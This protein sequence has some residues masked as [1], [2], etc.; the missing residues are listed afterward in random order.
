MDNKAVASSEAKAFMNDHLVKVLLIDDQPIV[1][2]TVRRMLASE[3]ELEFK[4]LSDPTQAIKVA[5]EYEPT[6]ILQDLV[7]PQL[8]GMTLV[9]FFRANPATKLIPMIVLSSRE[10]ATTKAEAF[11]LG[12][13]DYIVKLPDKIELIARIRYHSQGYINLLQRNEAY[14]A[15]AGVAHDIKNIVTGIKGGTY[16][17]DQ[18]MESD[19]KMML[20]LGWN[21][22]KV[23]QDRI[24]QLVYNM[25]DYSKNASLKY[26]DVDIETQLA[27]VRDLIALRAK[28]SEIVVEL[29][30]HSDAKTLEGEG[31]SLHRCILNLAGNALD[32]LP[33]SEPGKLIIRSRLDDK[34]GFIALE[35]EDNGP[36]IP[37]DVLPTLFQAFSSSK[38]G[39]G[40]GLGLAV[41]KKIA[42][43]HG[44]DIVVKST[45]GV[46][47]VFSVR[48]PIRKPPEATA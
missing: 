25:L 3:K 26:E 36:G 7:M 24:N 18:A 9:K 39:K 46:G 35:V 42:L 43:K 31:L 27:N 16:M 48:I 10:E 4:F 34:E 23:S 11:A 37:E 28:G 29:D 8:D 40:T 38:G 12:A 30:I 2:E 13:N 45:I 47:A 33:E 21:I 1:G 41:S 22:L 15:L 44:G 17:M 19:D 20:D 5:T 6:V 32:A 14:E